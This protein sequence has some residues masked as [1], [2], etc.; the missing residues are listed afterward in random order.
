MRTLSAAVAVCVAAAVCVAVIARG[1]EFP[2]PYM[3][4]SQ[5]FTGPAQLPWS[6]TQSELKCEKDSNSAKG[7]T[8]SELKCTNAIEGVKQTA[9]KLGMPHPAKPQAR[10]DSKQESYIS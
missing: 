4:F 5:N 10:T 1:N 6:N 3:S 9:L 2:Q 8:L 7:K